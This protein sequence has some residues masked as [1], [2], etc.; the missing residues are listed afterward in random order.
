MERGYL[1]GSFHDDAVI[2]PVHQFKAGVSFIGGNI[3]S[4][5]FTFTSD[6]YTDAILRNC[7]LQDREPEYS[8]TLTFLTDFRNK[9]GDALLQVFLLE[10]PLTHNNSIDNIRLHFIQL[11]FFVPCYHY[12]GFIAVQ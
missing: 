9:G 6:R 4:Q 11:E 12:N 7:V 5:Y 10:N 8:H 3:V 1:L 2:S